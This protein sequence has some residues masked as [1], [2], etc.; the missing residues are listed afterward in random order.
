MRQ[1]MWRFYVS[2]MHRS[3]RR[4]LTRGS[5]TLMRWNAGHFLRWPKWP[6]RGSLLIVR[7]WRRFTLITRKILTT[8]KESLFLTWIT[9][10]LVITNCL[11]MKM[12][13]LIRTL[14]RMVLFALGLRSTKDSISPV[15]PNCGI[16]SRQSSV[17]HPSTQRRKN[18]APPTQH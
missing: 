18:Q 6:I 14:G 7:S 10:F 2:S 9:R 12:G 17:K 4:S 1:K 8:S 5:D 11:E 15:T 3:T 16:D 13:R